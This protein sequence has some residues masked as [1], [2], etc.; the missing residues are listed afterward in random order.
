M[1][2]VES[3]GLTDDESNGEKQE[4]GDVSDYS[5][6]DISITDITEE[7]MP[8]E[9]EPEASKVE[10]KSQQDSPPHV[11]PEH[12]EEWS[13]EMKDRYKS[14]AKMQ[15]ETLTQMYALQIKVDDHINPAMN[16][17]ARKKML[18]LKIRVEKEL[19]PRSFKRPR[20]DYE[21]DE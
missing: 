17:Q 18:A 5:F 19:H 9:T 12:M 15:S 2:E 16:S 4:E 21:D 3:T 8:G 1:K 11:L 13:K 14:I 20:D 10:M 7:E 6:D